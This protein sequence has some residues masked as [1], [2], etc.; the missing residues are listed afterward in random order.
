MADNNGSLPPGMP[1]AGINAVHISDAA[2][3]ANICS[4]LVTRYIAAL[5]SD[6]TWGTGANIASTCP[7]GYD[8]GYFVS[9]SATDNRVTVAST[10]QTPATAS[11][12]AVR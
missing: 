1:A 10:Y 8:T 2:G 6:P 4:S 12:S 5:P 3:Q 9:V 11:I 7:A